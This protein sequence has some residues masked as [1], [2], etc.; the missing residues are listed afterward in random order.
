MQQYIDFYFFQTS[1]CIL[2]KKL[3]YYS[4]ENDCHKVEC[5]ILFGHHKHIDTSQSSSAQNIMLSLHT[6]QNNL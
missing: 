2:E 5:E 4:F 1:V 3:I 6:T